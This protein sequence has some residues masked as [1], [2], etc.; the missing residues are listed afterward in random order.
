LTE[1]HGI[2]VADQSTNLEIG[3]KILIVPNH[4]CVVT[5]MLDEIVVIT[6]ER[7]IKNMQVIGRGKVW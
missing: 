6:E 4:A 5:N 7:T 3:Q 1:E 2:I